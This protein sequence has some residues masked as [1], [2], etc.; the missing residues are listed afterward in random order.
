[1]N[2]TV[3]EFAA[4]EPEPTPVDPTGGVR[5]SNGTGMLSYSCKNYTFYH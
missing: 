4:A 3:E 1:M 2:I 5:A